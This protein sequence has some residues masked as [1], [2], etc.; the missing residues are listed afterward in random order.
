ML[1]EAF[2]QQ[3]YREDKCNKFNNKLFK[4]VKLDLRGAKTDPEY[5]AKKRPSYAGRENPQTPAPPL[6]SGTITHVR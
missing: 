4:I 1:I 2:Q 5:F 3:G 6:H